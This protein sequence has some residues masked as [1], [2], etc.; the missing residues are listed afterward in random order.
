MSESSPS[1]ARHPVEQM[2]PC[3]SS[4]M[5]RRPLAFLVILIVTGLA[6]ATAVLG[7]CA[8]MPCCFADAD[9]DARPVIGA[10][11]EDCCNTVSCYQAPPHESTAS[12]KAQALTADAP[13]LL[14]VAAVVPAPRAIQHVFV[15][16][17]PPRTTSERLASLSVL[18]I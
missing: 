6:P 5:N 18:L 4:L 2:L 8:K 13:A 7:F 10:D 14:P 9:H 11:M 17:S 1:A 3:S 16:L 12:A 15:D